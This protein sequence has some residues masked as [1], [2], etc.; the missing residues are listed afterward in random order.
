MIVKMQPLPQF[1]L[2]FRH[3]ISGSILVARILDSLLSFRRTAKPPKSVSSLFVQVISTMVANSHQSILATVGATR[4]GNITSSD[5]Q[6]STTPFNPLVKLYRSLDVKEL[7]FTDS[8]S[9]Y[10]VSESIVLLAIWIPIVLAIGWQFLRRT[11][12]RRTSRYRPVKDGA[13]RHASLASMDE[14]DEKEEEEATDIEEKT[15]PAAATTI[16]PSYPSASF[17][18]SSDPFISSELS[19]TS[20]NLSFTLDASS[21]KETEM[22][23]TLAVQV[24]E[25]E[26][27]T[28]IVLAMSRDQQLQRSQSAQIIG[29]GSSK[30]QYLSRKGKER[31]IVV[32][33][34]L[35]SIKASADEDLVPTAPS[36]PVISPVREIKSLNNV[37]ELDCEFQREIDRRILLPLEQ[38][39]DICKDSEAIGDSKDI[40][41]VSKDIGADRDQSDTKDRPSMSRP[42]CPLCTLPGL[43]YGTPHD[44]YLV[45]G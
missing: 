42:R 27:E 11:V 15:R 10:V 16:S 19:P 2:I 31:E 21:T 3:I 40:T 33:M 4:A 14:E 37:D 9:L 29:S 38:E 22:P 1:P 45:A 39:D 13:G 8:H 35:Q 25:G 30:S 20:C 23:E 6:I 32:D 44:C 34:D 41:G 5:V 28:T 24:L 18:S 36:S 12:F 26:P 17:S 43:I 7:E